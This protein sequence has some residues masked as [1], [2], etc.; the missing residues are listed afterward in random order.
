MLRF[1]INLS[2]VEHLDNFFHIWVFI[3]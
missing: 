1:F 2:I 3:S